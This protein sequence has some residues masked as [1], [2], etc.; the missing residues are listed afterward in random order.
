MNK[1]VGLNNIGNT[2][3]MNSIIQILSNT[4]DINTFFLN[5]KYLEILYN[6]FNESN[7]EKIGIIFDQQ[8]S[9][10]FGKVI[11]LLHSND[12]SFA[13]IDFKRIFGKKI[14]IFQGSEQQDSQEAFICIID[15]I[16]NEL[17]LPI[18]INIKNK[19]KEIYIL[20]DEYNGDDLEI[21]ALRSFL[22]EIKKSSIFKEVFQGL[23]HS[24]ISC[25][26]C[27]NISN[28]FDPI[29]HF[30]L[31]FPEKLDTNLQKENISKKNKSLVT[32]PLEMNKNSKQNNITKKWYKNFNSKSNTFSIDSDSSDEF[33]SYDDLNNDD[34]IIDIDEDT[35]YIPNFMNSN[36]SITK[37]NL[38]EIETNYIELMNE[39]ES[40]QIP[41]ESNENKELQLYDLFDNFIQT[42]ILDDNNKWYCSFC[43]DH[44]NAKKSMNIWY[45]PEILVIHLKRFERSFNGYSIINKKITDKVIFPDEL[46][47]DKYIDDKSP[48]KGKN[49]KY[50]LYAINNHQS[51]IFSKFNDKEKI[52]VKQI[53]SSG[54]DVGHYYSYVKVNNKWYEFNDEIVKEIK[55][56]VTEN[57]Y[58]L[59]YKLK[60]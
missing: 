58:L 32:I 1:L 2:C 47:L 7:I 60:Q 12:I 23:Q 27:D 45:L 24:N 6:K 14:E 57:A 40:K 29:L 16:H 4:P 9:F 25:P 44:V 46:M 59:F 22:R 39:Y 43:K 18:N 10:H 37:N 28:T 41:I 51:N 30:T 26:K 17:E 33:I 35:N 52:H 19:E 50:E 55:E 36:N 54:I 42:E 56:I 49:I 3:Y 20:S 38:S 5:N 11:K 53:T 34:Y 15:T 21:K 31:S 8:L 48:M 13:P